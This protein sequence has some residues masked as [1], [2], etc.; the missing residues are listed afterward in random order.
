MTPDWETDKKRQCLI[1]GADLE[2]RALVREEKCLS[3]GPGGLSPS[4]AAH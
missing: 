1:G 3:L 4:A 2:V